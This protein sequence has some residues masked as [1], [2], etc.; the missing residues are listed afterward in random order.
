[1]K[2]QIC[3]RRIK[4]PRGETKETRQCYKCRIKWPHYCETVRKNIRIDNEGNEKTNEI[5]EKF[6]LLAKDDIQKYEREREKEEAR[7]RE[8]EESLG[9]EITKDGIR[10]SKHVKLQILKKKYDILS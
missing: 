9:C 1:M 7:K 5:S 6:L 2:C 3:N 10:I 4:N 8:R